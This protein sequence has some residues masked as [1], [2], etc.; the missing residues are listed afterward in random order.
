MCL[1]CFLGQSQRTDSYYIQQMNKKAEAEEEQPTET[2]KPVKQWIENWITFGAA[3][4]QALGDNNFDITGIEKY[5]VR[6]GVGL[7]KTPL[8]LTFGADLTNLRA[9]DG[10]MSFSNFYNV[11]SMVQQDLHKAVGLVVAMKGEGFQLVGGPALVNFE[12]KRTDSPTAI[13]PVAFRQF[14]EEASAFG[15]PL[16]NGYHYYDWYVYLKAKLEL[17]ELDT[18]DG[19][20]LAS[21]VELNF[22]VPSSLEN[23]PYQNSLRTNIRFKGVIEWFDLKDL[24]EYNS[25]SKKNVLSQSHKEQESILRLVVDASLYGLDGNYS[26]LKW[27]LISTKI[28]LEWNALDFTKY[29]DLVLSVGWVKYHHAVNLNYNERLAN[30]GMWS[31][32]LLGAMLRSAQTK[33]RRIPEHKLID[34]NSPF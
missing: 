14:A 12:Y 19:S 13:E 25:E 23:N 33:K 20:L 4:H 18:K 30:N 24:M 21:E 10:S 11:R 22:R 8:M 28:S 3:Y 5:N 1:S 32:I 27:N 15:K 6:A 17:L 26:D 34:P 2:P 7:W 29:S 16:D 9:G 31:S